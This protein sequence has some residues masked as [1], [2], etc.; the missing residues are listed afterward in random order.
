LGIS[1]CSEDLPRCV[2]TCEVVYFGLVN[3]LCRTLIFGNQMICILRA[4]LRLEQR[5]KLKKL[6]WCAF[7]VALIIILE[8]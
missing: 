6:W 3:E 4:D 1:S 8:Q 2:G 5:F 7:A